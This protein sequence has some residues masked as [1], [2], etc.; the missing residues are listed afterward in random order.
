MGTFYICDDDA[1]PCV[2][3]EQSHSRLKSGRYGL[4]RCIRHGDL[5]TIVGDFRSREAALTWLRG[6]V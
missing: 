6:V 4:T 2:F 3:S 5:V 1:S